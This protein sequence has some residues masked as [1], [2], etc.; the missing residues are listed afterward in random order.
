MTYNVDFL[1]GLASLMDAA[2]VGVYKPTGVYDP[3]DKSITFGLTP[4]AP[5]MNFT[6]TTYPVND[7]DLTT[8]T[9]GVQFRIRGD[10]DPRTA[11]GMADD[12][13]NLLHNRRHYKLGP[14]SVELSWR[15]SAAWL[16][17]DT[18]QRTER[19]ENFY[20]H[21]ERAAPHQIA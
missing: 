2:G 3:A 1:D 7:T 6:I 4:L 12:L 18:D 21:A 13:Y 17:Q 15:Q 11:E 5:D 9:T 14:I 19:V 20:F 10:R 16:G 8:V